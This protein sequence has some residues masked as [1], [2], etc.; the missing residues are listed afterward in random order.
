M[1]GREIVRAW[2]NPIY[3]ASLG[4]EELSALPANPAGVTDLT[5]EQLRS[6]SGLAGIIVTTFRTCTEY[7]LHRYRCC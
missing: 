5:D 2:K 3:R 6:A 7:T 4:A 1:A